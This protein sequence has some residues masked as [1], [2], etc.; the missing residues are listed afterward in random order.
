MNKL[1][2]IVS[3]L[4]ES[5]RVL[6]SAHVAPDLD[7]VGS[8]GAL[9]LGLKSL[10]K[11]VGVCMPADM[12]NGSKNLIR[13]IPFVDESSFEQ[14]WDLFV[15]VDTA[16]EKRV[17]CDV[18]KARAC[19][20]KVVNIDHHI[21]NPSWGD[22][23]YIVSSSAA[24]A[25]IVLEILEALEADISVETA[26]LLYAGLADDTGCFRFSNTSVSTFENASKL[27]S[28]G[29]SPSDIANEIYFSVPERQMTLKGAALQTLETHFDGRLA[30]V[31]VKKQMLDAAGAN[32]QDT[33]G[34]VDIARSV[35]GTKAALF[36]CE[37]PKG[38]KASFRSKD[39]ALDVGKI[40][41]GF[42][43]GGHKA[44]AG[45]TVV[46]EF[47]EIKTNFISAF[48]TIL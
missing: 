43:G 31:V 24:S 38:W 45:C 34:L 36:I 12:P 14:K 26:S 42:G 35:E 30:V 25:E 39:E 40:A 5:S 19:S 18:E 28:K 8:A 13:S 22:L 16:T 46:G 6:I 27:V 11:E 48:K 20:G 37:T 4:K 10:G 1:S 47:D 2:Q 9:A 32:L 21:S 23:N 17:V 33:D 15:V 44:A 7:A 41:E 29:A 3:V